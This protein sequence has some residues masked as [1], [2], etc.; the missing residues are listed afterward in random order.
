MSREFSKDF[1]K[2]TTSLFNSKREKIRGGDE[3]ISDWDGFPSY[4]SYI[5]IKVQ[6]DVIK[7]FIIENGTKTRASS[8]AAES[9]ANRLT[10][11]EMEEKMI[12]TLILEY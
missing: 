3:D 11:W 9:Q 8:A 7:P 2:Q 12:A 1:P 6:W 5:Q 4:D 10:A